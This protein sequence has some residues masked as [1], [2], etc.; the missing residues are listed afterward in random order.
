MSMFTLAHVSPPLDIVFALDGS[1]SVC[2]GDD[3]WNR[4]ADTC[5]HW[6]E[7]KD[8]VNLIIDQLDVESGAVQVGLVSTERL[9]AEIRWNLDG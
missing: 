6:D 4:T 7:M 2:E 9:G 8:F 5:S 3:T 1:I